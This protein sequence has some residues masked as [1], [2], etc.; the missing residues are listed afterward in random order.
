MKKQYVLDEKDY[1]RLCSE[2]EHTRN[3]I[4]EIHR[5]LTEE[6]K[7][8]LRKDLVKM[9]EKLDGLMESLGWK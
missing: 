2:L 9:A 6:E 4:T 3:S 7:V 1:H 5:K 8:K